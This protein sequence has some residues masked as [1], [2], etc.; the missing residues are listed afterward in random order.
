MHCTVLIP[1]LASILSILI[2]KDK[3]IQVHTQLINIFIFNHYLFNI[4]F[5]Q[6]IIE[7]LLQLSFPFISQALMDTVDDVSA[8]AASAL[9]PIVDFMI[10]CDEKWASDVI[11]I[12]WQMLAVQDDLTASCYNFMTLLAALFS[13]PSGKLLT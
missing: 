5:F 7:K 3:L 1:G 4:F 9:L 8:V 12:L 6:D 13:L 11:S 2:F 10:K